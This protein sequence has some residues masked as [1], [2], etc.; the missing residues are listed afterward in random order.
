MGTFDIRS[1]KVFN[2]SFGKVKQS[3]KPIG[4][5]ELRDEIMRNYGLNG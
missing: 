2:A 1:P 5:N 4:T 3:M